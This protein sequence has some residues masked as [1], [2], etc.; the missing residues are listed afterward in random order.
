MMRENLP[1]MAVTLTVDQL[2]D[3]VRQEVTQAIRVGQA[4]GTSQVAGVQ[5]PYLSVS[6]AAEYSHMAES[7]IRQAIR[8]GR[9]VAHKVGRRVLLKKSELQDFIEREN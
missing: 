7:T 4:V 8:S 2:R 5:S 1:E 6:E 9:L 3:I